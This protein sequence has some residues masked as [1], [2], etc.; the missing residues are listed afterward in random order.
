MN[1]KRMYIF[2]LVVVLSGIL[3]VITNGKIWPLIV[4][5]V[6]GWGVYKFS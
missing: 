3:M 2:I 4:I 6:I 1:K 5:G